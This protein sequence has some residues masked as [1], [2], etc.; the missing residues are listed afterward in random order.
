VPGIYRSAAGERAVRRSYLDLLSKWPVP[1]QQLRVPTCQGETF[2]VASGPENAPPLM[3][4]HG[5]MMNAATWM[6]DVSIWATHFRV[7][8]VDIIGDS[9]LSAPSRP[10]LASDSYARWL[11]DVLGAL[12]IERTSIVGVSLGAWLALDYATRHPER[13]EHVA[14]L[15]PAG[16]GPT[17][18]VLWW[19][20]P[21]MLLGPWGTRKVSERILGGMPADASPEI[22]QFTAFMALIFENLK[23]RTETPPTFD[24]AALARLTMPVLTIVGEKDVML[25]SQAIVERLARVLPHAQVHC[26]PGAGHY[27]G[28]Q[29]VP[30]LKFLRTRVGSSLRA[31]SS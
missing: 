25:H 11:D 16:I 7:Y 20:L 26:L 31:A 30:V 19:A 8:A 2:I 15:C 9:G 21:L 18:N 24:D 14:L 1:N 12:G 29:R 22:K 27:L 10:P 13:V 23:P 5:S 3:L 28:D 4:L 6:G 17:R